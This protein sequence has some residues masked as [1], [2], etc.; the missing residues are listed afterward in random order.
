MAYQLSVTKD[1]KARSFA[2]GDD[3]A[4]L[5]EAKDVNKVKQRISE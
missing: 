4:F 3:G 5:I 1:M 2:A